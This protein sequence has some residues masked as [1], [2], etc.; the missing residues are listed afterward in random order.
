MLNSKLKDEE[1]NQDNGKSTA[2]LY[3]YQVLYS[4]KAKEK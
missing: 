2:T 4:V 1:E 3:K